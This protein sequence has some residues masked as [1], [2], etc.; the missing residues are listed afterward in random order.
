MERL[1]K[2]EALKLITRMAELVKELPEEVRIGR[3]FM[4]NDGKGVLLES[5]IHAAAEAFGKTVEAWPG[6]S[7]ETAILRFEVKGLVICEFAQKNW[8]NDLAEHKEVEMAEIVR[9]HKCAKRNTPEC[10]MWYLCETCGGQ[11]SWETD[12]DFCSRGELRR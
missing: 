9:C 2:T 11:W 10:S 7:K 12:E 3:L 4:V 8:R 5:G 6:W 1:K